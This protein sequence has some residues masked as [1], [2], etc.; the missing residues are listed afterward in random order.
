MLDNNGLIHAI[1]DAL[2]QPWIWN[3]SLDRGVLFFP[4]IQWILRE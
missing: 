2:I 1:L 3:Y 4:F